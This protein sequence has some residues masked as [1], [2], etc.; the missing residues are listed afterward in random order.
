MSIAWETALSSVRYELLSVV[1]LAQSHRARSAQVD[2][3]YLENT[4]VPHPELSDRRW[5]LQPMSLC[6]RLARTC[7][8]HL[9]VRLAPARL[10]WGEIAQCA[11]ID[12]V[13][14]VRHLRGLR[15]AVLTRRHGRGC[16]SIWWRTG[17]TV[18]VDHGG[19]EVRQPIYGRR[20]EP[21]VIAGAEVQQ[22]R[23][24]RMGWLCGL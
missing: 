24:T 6:Q 16:R 17:T 2:A 7:S 20:R 9:I 18:V 22:G 12:F 11:G 19:D 13:G 3:R 15:L 10:I 14:P 1:Q 5:P 21:L 8:D 23:P 4:E